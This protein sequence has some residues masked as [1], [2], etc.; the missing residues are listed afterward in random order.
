[1]LPR[2]RP[3]ADA[4][5]RLIHEA[6]RLSPSVRELIARLDDTDLFV[7]VQL[8]GTPQVRT[9]STSF[10]AST[11]HGRYLRIQISAGLPAWSRIH[12]LGHE[13]QHALEIG[14]D[15]SVTSDDALR[16]LYR[17]IGH[18]SDGDDRF[19]TMEARR[20]E[21]QVRSEL[22]KGAGKPQ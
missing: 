21:Y 17:R 19:E 16:A 22:L 14:G 1:M 7:Y 3:A 18:L 20:I 2:L 12:L 11:P 5:Q 8:T 4:E 13:L 9:G 10:V 6:V 15:V